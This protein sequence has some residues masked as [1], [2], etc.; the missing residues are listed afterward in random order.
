ME[1][2]KQPATPCANCGGVIARKPKGNPH[3]AFC[4]APCRQSFHRRQAA[5]GQVALPILMAWRAS[6]NRKADREVGRQALMEACRLMDAWAA[7]DRVAGRPPVIGLMK[8]RLAV[9]GSM[10][11]D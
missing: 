10:A 5:R 7:D 2:A 4:G 3:A 11:R 8:S 1:T 9:T 6:R